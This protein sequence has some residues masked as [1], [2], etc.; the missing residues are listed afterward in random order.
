MSAARK[1]LKVSPAVN[2]RRLD[3]FAEID[4]GGD[5]SETSGLLWD[6]GRRQSLQHRRSTDS[7]G[8]GWNLPVRKMSA[9]QMA[10]EMVDRVHSKLRDFN[11]SYEGSAAQGEG[12][13]E[14]MH[15]SSRLKHPKRVLFFVRVL[16]FFS[17]LFG[18]ALFYL[19]AYQA[20]RARSELSAPHP[21][22]HTAHAHNHNHSR[23]P[24]LIL[25]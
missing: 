12:S 9:S 17:V 11:R 4:L 19:F 16:F 5:A 10:Y 3:T 8:Y 2:P 25:P 21:L 1:K 18:A 13:S 6:D 14:G 24:L 7:V 23:F 20:R 22:N 15:W